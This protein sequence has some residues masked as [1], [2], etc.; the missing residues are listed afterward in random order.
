MH[1][2]NDLRLGPIRLSYDLAYLV[3]I[4]S[5]PVQCLCFVVLIRD[6]ERK[7]QAFRGLR[8]AA[9]LTGLC[10]LLAWLSG[11]GNSTYGPGLGFSG[12][13]I[14]S[15][16]CANSILL[17][18]L[19]VF[20][21][22]WALDADKQP[23]TA[24]AL[25]LIA[26]AM[27]ANGTKACYYGLFAVFGA[28]A[29]YL[30]ADALLHRKRLRALPVAFLLLGMAAAVLVYPCTP[31]CR[32]DQALA[33]A[34]RAG[35]TE[36]VLREQGIDV[37]AMSPEERY[38]NPAVRAV[39]GDAYRRYMAAMPDL[40][41][42]FGIDRVLRHYRMTTDVRRL[43][44]SREI[45]RS[46]AF[47]LWEDSDLLTRLVGFEA[48]Q[49]GFDGLYDLEN[50]GHALFY[51]CG[52]LGFALYLGF[53][54]YFVFRILRQLRRDLRGSLTAE[55]WSLALCLGLQLGLA[56]FSGALVRRPNV[57]FYLALV[58]ALIWFQTREGGESA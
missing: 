14:D 44:D 29:L 23:I 8:R 35:E 34:G 45:E 33:L 49:M 26:L 17:V 24:G 16:R 2:L 12:W 38:Q 4:L 7:E 21:S 13:V 55:N 28:F 27:L 42:R 6:E 36:T 15:N 52:L 11:T 37:T 58:L 3:K 25:T 57:S 50:D 41:D 53:L 18:T 47:F 5:M 56:Q 32:V 39:M 1:L 19:S 48:S 31:R 30:A 54:L 43:I 9:A 22:A 10:L 40:I 46:Y 20:A 51:T